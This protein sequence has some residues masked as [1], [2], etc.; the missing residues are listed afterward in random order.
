MSIYAISDLHLSLGVDKPM[1]VFKGW[2]NYVEKLKSNWIEKITENDTVVI[3]GDISWGMNFEESY[4]DFKF[5]DSLPGKKVLIKGNHDY[6]WSTKRK[7]ENFFKDNNLN[8]L[9]IVHNSAIRVGDHCICGTRGWMCTM[10]FRKDRRIYFRELGRLNTS[11]NIAKRLGGEPIVFLHY[12]PVYN[13]EESQEIIN[14][15]IERKVKKCYYGHIHGSGADRK[16]ILG[17]YKGIDFSLISCDYLKFCP[18]FV[19]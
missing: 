5:I 1:D 3:A 11:L 13:F 10:D 17:N 6:W 8:S 19:V 18:E 4:E 2:S 7:I 16:V 9:S 14:I 12:P 15:L